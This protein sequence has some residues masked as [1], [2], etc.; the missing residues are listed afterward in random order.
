MGIN[1]RGQIVGYE[2]YAGTNSAFDYQ[3]V[4][5]SPSPVSA[6]PLPPAW[7]MMLISLAVLALLH[8]VIPSRVFPT[9]HKTAVPKFASVRIG[10]L[11]SPALKRSGS[12]YG[13]QSQPAFHHQANVCV[14]FQIRDVLQGGLGADH[15]PLPLILP[16][17]ALR[18]SSWST[19]SRTRA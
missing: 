18:R 2:Y 1:N 14:V 8:I 6:T 19:V 11:P 9:L 16:S 4:V 10:P 17:N 3:A 5:W 15:V 13:N 12:P 7:T